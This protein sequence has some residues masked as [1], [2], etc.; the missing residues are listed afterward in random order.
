MEEEVLDMWGDWEPTEQ[1]EIDFSKPITGHYFCEIVNIEYKEIHSDSTGNDYELIEIKLKAV[2]D[3]DGDHAF[4]RILSKAYFLGTSEWNSD[5]IAGYKTM[6]SNLS[7]SGLFEDWMK[8]NDIKGSVERMNNELVGKK[9][10]VSAF[11]KEGKQQI[12]IV[13]PKTSA[14]VV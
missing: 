4:N 14:S 8:N 1:E 2:E 10:Y 12:R 7:S 5:P 6:L 13:R 11:A 3:V 9:V